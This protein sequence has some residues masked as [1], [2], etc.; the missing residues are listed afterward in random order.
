VPP[1]YDYFF[2]HATG[3]F[4]STMV[5][6]FCAFFLYTMRQGKETMPPVEKLLFSPTNVF[7][8]NGTHLRFFSP[9]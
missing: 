9:S 7:R 6:F 8:F 5:P 2:I 1:F 3:S 4:L